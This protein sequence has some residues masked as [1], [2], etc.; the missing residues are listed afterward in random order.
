MTFSMLIAALSVSIFAQDDAGLGAEYADLEK[1]AWYYSAVESALRYGFMKGTHRANGEDWLFSPDAALTREQFVTILHRVASA[2][3]NYGV[4]Q[5]KNFKDIYEY[6][7]AFSD[8]DNLAWY[9]SSL[10]W[11]ESYGITNGVSDSEFG[12]NRPITREEMATLIV[13]FTDMYS[14][15]SIPNSQK[16]PTPFKDI[17]ECSDWAK[18]SVEQM[19]NCNIIMGDENGNFNP[20]QTATRCEAAAV[21][22]RLFEKAELDIGAVFD[23]AN[24]KCIVF[25]NIDETT[26]EPK[27]FTVG[28]PNELKDTL[29]HFANGEILDSDIGSSLL[30]NCRSLTVYDS[31]DNV[32]CAF[33]I[34]DSSIYI[35]G[36]RLYDYTDGYFKTFC[37]RLG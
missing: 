8:V 17:S 37:D 12:I 6:R 24:V 11:V 19:K 3:P 4:T 2:M 16:D 18:S 30:G 31:S 13:R 36:F 10:M 15:I 27:S 25:S 23:P 22:V 34:T 7:S 33:G 28:D 1:D 29:A 21:F 5:L 32:V 9:G 14:L 35:N 20:K 26:H